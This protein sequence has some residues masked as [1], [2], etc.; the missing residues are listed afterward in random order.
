[1]FNIQKF[2]LNILFIVIF[3]A[4]KE[5]NNEKS[6]AILVGTGMASWYG[7]GFHGKI[8]ANGEKFNMN[9]FTAAHRKLKFGTQLRITNLKN[10][11]SVVVRVNDRGPYN[12]KRVIDLS[13][14]AAKEIDMIKSGLAN[15]KIEI[16][17]YKSVSF[18]SFYYHY[19]NLLV[20]NLEK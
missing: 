13:K 11:L 12:H 9:T 4:C 3:V 2:V 5:N 18:K 1:M 20:I 8:T 6:S 17:G 10:D 19:Q 14:T 7:P 16:I 15:V